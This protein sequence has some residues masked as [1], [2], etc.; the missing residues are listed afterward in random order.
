MTTHRI[1]MQAKGLVKRYGAKGAAPKLALD[2]VD[3]DIPR[4]ELISV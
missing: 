3:L 1:V 4:G 2:H